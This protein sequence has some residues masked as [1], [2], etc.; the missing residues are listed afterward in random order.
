MDTLEKV[1]AVI[2]VLVSIT[3]AT[4]LVGTALKA[5]E[6][7]RVAIVLIS[8]ELSALV[9]LGAIFIARMVFA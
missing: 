5:D 2:L 9:I 6:V 4:I 3:L 1:I 7:A 8:F